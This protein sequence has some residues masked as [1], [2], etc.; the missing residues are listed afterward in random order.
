MIPTLIV[1]L[2]AFAAAAVLFLY[3]QNDKNLTKIFSESANGSVAAATD[4]GSAIPELPNDIVIAEPIAKALS[5]IKKKPFAIYVSPVFSTVNPERFT[6]YHTGVDF[7]VTPNE[8]DIDIP[9]YAIC[10]GDILIKKTASGYGG[11]INQSCTIEGQ[12]VTV[13]Y[14]HLRLS[15]IVKTNGESLA[16]GE[17]IGVLGEANSP[18][19]D[20]ER[21]H[22]HLGIHKGIK[23]VMT[24][25]V[26]DFPE[27]EQWINVIDYLRPKK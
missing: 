27:L 7:E 19:T 25:Y 8:K 10:P 11:V 17:Q 12:A 5:R 18:E 4:E 16:Q 21:K 26:A 13:T 1:L 6:G 15:S 9:V 20:K 14:G 22:L 23:P 24:G 2:V 3:D